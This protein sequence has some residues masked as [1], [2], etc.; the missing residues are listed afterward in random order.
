MSGLGGTRR[1]RGVVVLIGILAAGVLAGCAYE[2]EGDPRPTAASSSVRQAAA[3]PTRGQDVLAMETRNRAELDQRLAGVPGSVLLEGSGPADGSGVG[4]T[5]AANGEV[6]WAAHRHCSMLGAPRVQFMLYQDV[7][8]GTE[9][10]EFVLDCSA[11]ETIVVQLQKGSL[12]VQLT[13]NDPDGAWTGALL[14]RVR[15]LVRVRLVPAGSTL[16]PPPSPGSAGVT[17]SWTRPPARLRSWRT[18]SPA[19]R[20]VPLGHEA[21]SAAA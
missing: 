21:E 17:R 7:K 4:F 8:G 5:T 11:S 6:R 12:R 16:P 10:K 9:H 14:Q 3:M 13:R 2:D 18:R 19:R 1:V 15:Y 20:S